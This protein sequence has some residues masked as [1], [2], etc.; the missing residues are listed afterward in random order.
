[1]DDIIKEC[2]SVFVKPKKRYYLGKTAFG[3]PY[4]YPRGFLS[5]IFSIRHLVTKN[6]VEY[7]KY[8]DRYPHLK[9]ENTAIYSNYPIVR[10]NRYWIK[11]IFG[12]TFFIEVGFPFCIY[13]NSLGWKDKFSMPRYEWSPAFYIFF[14]NWQ[15]CVWWNAPDDDNDLYYEMMLWYARYSGHDIKKAKETWG[16]TDYKTKQS[17]WNDNYLKH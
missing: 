1:M 8:C 7:K 14:F 5:S 4:F 11:K 10:R 17:T 12:K 15:F 9:N 16:W 13:R 6:E 2:S 3:T